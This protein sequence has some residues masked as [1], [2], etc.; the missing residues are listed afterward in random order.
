[1]QR[2]D[3]QAPHKERSVRLELTP[4]ELEYVRSALMLLESTLGREEADE[5][6]EVIDLLRRV[7]EARGG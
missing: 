5:L 7:E 4:D 2:P 6:R 3:D 1:M